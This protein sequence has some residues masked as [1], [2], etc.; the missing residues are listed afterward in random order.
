MTSLSRVLS[1]EQTKFSVVS[2][3]EFFGTLGN[4]SLITFH[5]S[6]REINLNLRLI[7]GRR[8]IQNKIPWKEQSQMSSVAILRSLKESIVAANVKAV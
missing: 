3:H 1:S 2:S 8:V 4:W 6:F 7:C 5:R